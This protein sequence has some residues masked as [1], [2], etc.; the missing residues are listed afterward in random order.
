MEMPIIDMVLT[1]HNIEEM[2]K[3]RNISVRQLQ[4]MFG[5]ESPQ[6]IYKWQRGLC[7]PTIDNLVAL[8]MIFEVRVDDI[9]VLAS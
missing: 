9:L 4:A 8:A 1:G 6:S 5:F 2:R 7:L 3:G